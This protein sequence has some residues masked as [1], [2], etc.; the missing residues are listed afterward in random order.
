MPAGNGLDYIVQRNYVLALGNSTCKCA[1][2]R[3]VTLNGIEAKSLSNALCLSLVTMIT[4][5]PWSYVS[6]TLPCIEATIRRPVTGSLSLLHLRNPQTRMVSH[7]TV[8][9]PNGRSVWVK[10]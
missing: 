10:H 6:R 9:L 7:T 5:G 8:F 2:G 1:T 4:A 3:A